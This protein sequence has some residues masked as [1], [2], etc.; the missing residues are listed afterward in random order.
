M[1]NYL[2][3][4]LFYL[5]LLIFYPEATAQ[6]L[7][8]G[9]EI[10]YASPEEFE[11]GGIAV[12][13]SR[14]LDEGAI[15]SLAGIIPGE[16]IVIPGEKISAAIENLWKQNLFA[17][18]SIRAGKIIR[19]PDASRKNIMYLEI[20]VT[21]KPRL[22]KFSFSGVNK[23]EADDLREKINLVK[24]KPITDHLKQ[25][26]FNA[27]NLYFQDKG[28]LNT[29][30]SLKEEA[31]SG[32]INSVT[33]HINVNKGHKVRIRE[34][35]IFGNKTYPSAK[36]KR[37][38]KETKEKPR[39]GFF[40]DI[41]QKLKN[42][43]GHVFK[44]FT[45]FT[46]AGNPQKMAAYLSTNTRL[47]IF[48]S[49]KFMD[50]VYQGEKNNI[51]GKYKEGGF[52]DARIINDSVYKTDPGNLNIDIT[53]AE[54]RKYY[55][56]NITWIGNTKH[57]TQELSSILNIKK[58][59]VYNQEALDSR[60]MMNP[61]GRDVSSLYL[62][63]GYLFFNIQPVEVAVIND[64]IDLE[65]R[66]AEGRQATINRVSVSG[67]TKTNDRVIMREVR[68]RPG[69]LFSRADI[70]R[71]QRELATLGY[72]DPEKMNINTRPDPSEGTVDLEYIVEE[73]PSDQ[74]EL[75]GGWG[76]GQ[77]VGTLGVTFNNFSGRN[78]FKG[79]S[80][81]PLPSGDGQR[82][83]L[84]A[85]TSGRF[86]Q[87]Y[88]ASFTEPWL[89]GKKP[90]SMSVSAFHTDY[91]YSGL[92]K[93]DPRR[94][95]MNISGGAIG[96]GWRLKF[97][98]DFFYRYLE[99]SYN[100]Y[101]L[102]NYPNFIL[103]NGFANDF[104]VGLTFSRNSLDQP[105]TM[106]PRSG[107]NISI[108]VQATPPYSLLYPGKDYAAVSDQEKYRLIEYHKWKFSSSWFQ[109]ISGDLV[110]NLRTRFGYIGFYNPD[111]D[112][113]MGR[114]WLG[115][116]GLSGF[117]LDGREI[118]AL[119]GYKDFYLTPRGKNSSGNYSAIGGT[120]FDKFTLELR[121]PITLAPSSTI[122]VLGFAEAGNNWLKFSEFKPFD[123]KRSAGL[124]VRITLPMFGQLGLDYG[125]GFDQSTPENPNIKPR[126]EFHFSIGQSI[127]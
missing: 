20:H 14:F 126:G 46:L 61:E 75:S 1:K 103:T 82:L 118:V 31:D 72:F 27:V 99:F 30:V 35:R 120:V 7:L 2:K 113:V 122:Y 81:N 29:T 62:D 107:S 66:I 115:G 119:R 25:T 71:T 93:S 39:I 43:S 58:G 38:L 88:N 125:W 65:L 69:Q 74:V 85:Q 33:L 8:G 26:T 36:L 18:I 19:N 78:I 37:K 89:G 109:R 110:A 6:V 50:E 3:G 76:A 63:D 114:F 73:K 42:G 52:R 83:S 94:Q 44:P 106:Y 92:K 102:N 100:Y 24:G 77:L 101:T 112:P 23:S 16:V 127:E 90:N 53:I 51:L 59:D 87:S 98:D 105:T 17:E 80:W 116:S 34:I 117:S 49:S 91:N 21:E 95:D 96:F 84:R 64:S 9:D 111:I 54:G 97:P 57:S 11:I 104:N 108:T 41:N 56:R 22:S 10:D 79:E 32:I 28:F 55:F 86:F 12:V 4:F 68:S 40:R 13:G 5:T 60:L 47:N 123:L 124:G 15:L 67:N 70:I 45:L 121:Y 48:A